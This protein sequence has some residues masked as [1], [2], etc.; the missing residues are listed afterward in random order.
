MF[1]MKQSQSNNAAKHA[2]FYLTS[3]F[4]LGVVAI[5]IGTLFFQIINY[6]FPDDID[7]WRQFSQTALKFA[8]SSL[9]IA[10]PVYYFVTRN[11]NLY[12]SKKDLDYDSGVRKWLTYIVLFIAIAIVIGDLITTVFNFLDGELTTRFILK[13][14]TILLIAGGIFIYYFTDIKNK[15]DASRR[16]KNTFWSYV[17]LGFV[18]I[19]FVWSIFIIESPNVARQRKIDYKTIDSFQSIKNMINNFADIKNR[20]P[21]NFDELKTFSVTQM[22]SNI[23]WEELEQKNFEY[24]II[25]KTHYQLCADFLR[26]NREDKDNSKRYYYFDWQHASGYYCFDLEALLIE[27]DENDK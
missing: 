11:I 2:F 17:F 20:I 26:D 18:L 7:S 1:N 21:P 13:A 10:A 19:P 8:I 12:I 15:D 9:I 14:L 3:F 23:A 25:D 4:T 22:Y 27:D 24:K 16:K 6:F 5:G